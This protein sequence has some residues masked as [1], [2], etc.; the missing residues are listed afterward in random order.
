VKDGK[1]RP[2]IVAKWVANAPLEMI[3]QYESNLKKYYAIAIDIGTAD[4]LLAANKQ[5]HDAMTRLRIP[6][7]YED[8]D[9]DHT[10][11]VR[12]RI[13][14]H[15]LPFFSKNLAAPANPTSPTPQN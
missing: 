7:H 13:E 11:K 3:G 15:V 10:N 8:Y 9:G 1:V 2:D 6:H 14:M 4:P 12:D 5:L